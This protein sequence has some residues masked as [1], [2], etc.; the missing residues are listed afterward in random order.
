MTSENIIKRS[1][2]RPRVFDKTR[3]LK[4]AL[5]LFWRQGYEGSSIAQLTK[6]MKITAPSLY[7]AFGSKEQLYREVLDLYISTQGDTLARSLG[8][9]G[10]AR[11][12]IGHMLTEAATQF[13]R[14]AWPKG[15]LVSNGAIRCAKGN[16]AAVK[17]TATLRSL[18]QDAI[19][20]RIDRAIIDGELT[21]GTDAVELA[22]FYASVIH[23]MSVQAVD[24]ATREQLIRIGE[25]AIAAWPTKVKK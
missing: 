23:G 5:I 15:C 8:E 2:G 6:A 24:G 13:S 11:I 25:Y 21:A 19:R 3:A 7:A 17:A 20:Q 10:S 9:P 16:Q 18:G 22:A 14:S 1:R 12:A 4:A